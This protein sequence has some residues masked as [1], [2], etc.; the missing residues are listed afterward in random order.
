MKASAKPPRILNRNLVYFSVLLIL[1]GIGSE[2]YV[3]SLLGLLLL[4]PALLSPARPPVRRTPAPR[5]EARRIVPQQPPRVS[6][7]T[8]SPPH[9]I[10]IA[11]T[12]PVQQQTYTPALFPMPMFPSLSQMG[13]TPQPVKEPAQAKQEARDELVEV[14]T[15]LALLKLAFG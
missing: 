10:E 15:I 14:G 9:T 6:T 13:S 8:P 2:V 4:I 3:L 1:L 7:Q 12:P 5:Q 11:P